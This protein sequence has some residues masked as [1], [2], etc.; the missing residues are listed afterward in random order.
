MAA[1][2]PQ[3]NW[4]GQ[5]TSD[6]VR[7][8]QPR[9]RLAGARGH[10]SRT[11]ALALRAEF[12]ATPGTHTP[13]APAMIDMSLDFDL[14]FLLEVSIGIM[15]S[16][17]SLLL[18][19]RVRQSALANAARPTG[20]AAPGRHRRNTALLILPL[21]EPIMWLAFAIFTTRTCLLA[22]PGP[23]P[24]PPGWYSGA[25]DSTAEAVETDGAI[26]AQLLVHESHWLQNSALYFLYWFLFEFL[27]EGVALFFVFPTP[28]GHAIGSA[29]KYAALLALAL[30]VMTTI[31]F[32]YDLMNWSQRLHT[33]LDC[34]F[35]LLPCALHG[36]L[37]LR[38][39]CQ[40]TH[41]T[42][43]ASITYAAFNL[44]W[45]SLS[46]ASIA[47]G[48]SESLVG[49]ILKVVRAGG[50]PLVLYVALASDSRHWLATLKSVMTQRQVLRITERSA[51]GAGLG[52]DWAIGAPLPS[53][54]LGGS[55]PPPP[56]PSPPPPP[57]PPGPPPPP[58]H[59]CLP[60]PPPLHQPGHA[61]RG[62]GG[63]RQ[64]RAPAGTPPLPW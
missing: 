43:S 62:R 14:S 48:I 20:A 13:P 33:A 42:R 50:T 3:F 5:T 49:A 31:A 54:A 45:R 26:T 16:C 57:A 37:L 61:W 51:R 38:P 56:P 10:C 53:A 60:G 41:A 4:G 36:Y 63:R 18:A 12:D 35:F 47:A 25:V 40:H 64:R 2:P 15:S 32:N 8:C 44:F 19:L 59:G 6:T 7:C 17:I 24:T 23:F 1:P 29:V 22:V 28:S 55:I 21:Y 9:R 46:A 27:V 52:E 34:A 30:A 58:P 39:A 11:R